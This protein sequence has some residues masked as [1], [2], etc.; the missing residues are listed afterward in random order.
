MSKTRLA[1]RLSMDILDRCPVHSPRFRALGASEVR[2]HDRARDL[3]RLLK[4]WPDEAERVASDDAREIVRRL[5]SALRAERQRGL[6]RHWVYDLSR[7]LALV[8]A[9]RAELE[10]LARS[11][12][13]AEQP[14]AGL[15]RQSSIAKRMTLT[16]GALCAHLRSGAQSTEN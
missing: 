11:A 15:P 9:L 10:R 1:R 3:P 2:S 6:Y 5:R 12:R 14:L 13:A 8:R 16:D 4:L 7:H